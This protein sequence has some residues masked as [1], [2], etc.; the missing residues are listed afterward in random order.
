MAIIQPTPDHVLDSATIEKLKTV[1]ST[2]VVDILARNG[3]DPRYVYMANV[4]TM[5]PGVRLVAR[6]ITVRFLPARPDLMAEKRAVRNR[7]NTQRLN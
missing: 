6:A 4:K 7:P 1:N 5:N 3:H 2:A